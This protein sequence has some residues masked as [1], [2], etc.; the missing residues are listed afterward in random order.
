[1]KIA[2]ARAALL[3]GAAAGAFLMVMGSP[4]VAGAAEPT[5]APAAA[6]QRY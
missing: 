6:Q 2:G 5:A 4:A 1:M 3:A